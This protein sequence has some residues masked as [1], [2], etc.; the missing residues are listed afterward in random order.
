LETV[1]AACAARH[2]YVA[3]EVAR[4][5]DTREQHAEATRGSDT[6]NAQATSDGRRATSD[7][8]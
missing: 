6:R 3:A 1:H 2:G 4:A 8:R 7:E 5:S